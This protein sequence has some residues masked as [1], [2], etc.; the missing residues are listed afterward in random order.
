[1]PD[2]SRAQHRDLLAT[3]V[4]AAVR[5][6]DIIA[7]RSRD[8]GSMSALAWEEKRPADFVSEVDRAAERAIA[9]IIVARHPAAMIVGEE[10]SPDVGGGSGL[11]FIVDP[12]DGTTNFLHGY[13]E[14]AVSIAALRDGELAAGVVLNVTTGE[15]FT[16]TAGAGARRNGEPIAVSSLGDPGRALI[17]TGFPF[18]HL[19]LL[20]GYQRQLGTVI[21]QTAG[22]RR[23]GSA[24]L[25]LADVA[26]GRFDGFWELR[27]A[28]WDVAAGL[29]MVR[30]AGGVATDLEG[31]PAPV[32][33]G[34][35]VAG[36]ALLHP[37]L[38]SLV[39]QSDDYGAIDDH[40]TIAET[41]E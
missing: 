17:G 29:L 4:A 10:L 37:W 1:M 16:A 38:L 9:E 24:A 15:L 20:P 8:A 14:Y 6:A 11:A 21:R 2:A 23:A 36:N 3:A 30:E 31:S 5:A 18:K 39:R 13:P 28:P 12:L 35:I 32:S 25:D 19:E 7:S 33:H 40:G 22:V 27:L 41:G 34:G 26:C